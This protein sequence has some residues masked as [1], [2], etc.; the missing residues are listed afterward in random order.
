MSQPKLGT[1]SKKRKGTCQTCGKRRMLFF[2]LDRTQDVFY[3]NGRKIF[4][5]SAQHQ[6]ECKKLIHYYGLC[7]E[8]FPKINHQDDIVKLTRELAG[9]RPKRGVRF[10]YPVIG[11]P[12][13]GQYAIVD[14]FKTTSG[15]PGETWY[16]EG[17]IYGHLAKEYHEFNA[18]HGGRKV[19]GGFPSMV[20]LHDSLC[21]PL[22]RPKDR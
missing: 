14:D 13:D 4:I 12:L 10:A 11:G 5:N 7:A 19:I 3:K 15:K 20:F 9:L 1:Y 2:P 18:G 8:C 22:A 16:R 17:G 6:I 21:R